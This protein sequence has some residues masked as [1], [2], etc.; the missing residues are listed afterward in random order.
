MYFFTKAFLRSY[1]DGI[2]LPF[3]LMNDEKLEKNLQNL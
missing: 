3:D 2:K 1:I